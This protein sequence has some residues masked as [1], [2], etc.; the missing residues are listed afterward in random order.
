MLFEDESGW[1][2]PVTGDELAVILQDFSSLRLA[3]LNACEGARSSRHDPFSG[4]AGA[5]IQRDVPAVIAMQSAISDDSA[6]TFAA[7]FYETLAAGAAVDASLAAA[8][9]SMFARR[10]EDTEWG[11]PVLLMRVAD[12]RL[13]DLQ[14]PLMQSPEAIY[15]RPS[16][17]DASSPRAV[18]PASRPG[19]DGACRRAD[20]LCSLSLR[21]GDPRDEN[22]RVR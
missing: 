19:G 6:I 21:D 17:P 11:K 5:L 2:R 12:S 3:V 14:E 1:A 7:S 20:P 8:R 9:L 13:F 4:V 10:T 22:R 16:A 18:A 15:E